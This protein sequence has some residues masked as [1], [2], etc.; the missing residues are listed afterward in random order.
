MADDGAPSN[1]TQLIHSLTS[2]LVGRSPVAM[3]V[4]QA[5]FAI[6]GP[7]RRS[8]PPISDGAIREALASDDERDRRRHVRQLVIIVGCFL[9]GLAL[10]AAAV[11]FVYLVRDHVELIRVVLE[12]IVLIVTHGSV[13]VGGYMVGRA[14]KRSRTR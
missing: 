5:F 6:S 11:A 9:T 10:I 8:R 1:A 7:G 3:T 12:A 14:A 2:M 4:V 13:G